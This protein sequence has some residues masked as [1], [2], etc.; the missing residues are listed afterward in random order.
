MKAAMGLT[1]VE[2]ITIL[3]VE[4]VEDLK[5]DNADPFAETTVWPVL[6]DNLKEMEMKRFE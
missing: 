6:W 3:V 5:A 4:E 2:E 1:S